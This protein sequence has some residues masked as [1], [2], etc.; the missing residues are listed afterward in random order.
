MLDVRA[1]KIQAQSK[2]KVEGWGGD[3]REDDG[4]PCWFS[5]FRGGRQ[6][7]GRREEGGSGG[8]QGRGSEGLIEEER[9]GTRLTLRPC[10]MHKP[11]TRDKK[12]S[13]KHDTSKKAHKRKKRKK[14]TIK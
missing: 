3:S 10:R 7:R 8:G 5:S 2:P 9:S 12:S 11:G 4:K 1:E 14:K 6:K 13:Q